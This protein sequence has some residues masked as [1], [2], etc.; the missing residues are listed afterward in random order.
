M[1]VRNEAMKFE[2]SRDDWV[3]LNPFA[4]LIV[5]PGEALEPVAAEKNPETVFGAR[6]EIEV[7]SEAPVDKVPDPIIEGMSRK[8]SGICL[9]ARTTFNKMLSLLYCS[10]TSRYAMD[11]ALKLPE[12]VNP[13]QPANTAT[14]GN[15]AKRSALNI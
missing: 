15:N 14:A 10:T 3:K 9:A 7:F 12:L 5:N 6:L 4:T 2:L 8:L 13:E 11:I 1:S